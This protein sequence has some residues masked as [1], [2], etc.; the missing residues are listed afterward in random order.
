[1][2]LPYYTPIH[3]NLMLLLLL[4][5]LLVSL[6]LKIPIFCYLIDREMKDFFLIAIPGV[7]SN[8][9]I[10]PKERASSF[11]WSKK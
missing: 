2:K 8:K 3:L 7:C 4:L 10:N 9:D 6:A 1:M 5:F 11:C